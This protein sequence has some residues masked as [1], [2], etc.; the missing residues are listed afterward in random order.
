MRLCVYI[1][2]GSLPEKPIEAEVISSEI[3]GEELLW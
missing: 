1:N 3:A 2:S